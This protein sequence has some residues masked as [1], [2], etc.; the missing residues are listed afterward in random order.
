MSW[1]CRR[2]GTPFAILQCQKKA[3]EYKPNIIFL[4]ETRL[5]K[6]KGEAILQRCGFWNSWEYL[7]EGFS[8]GLLLG[9][10][11]D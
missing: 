5:A 7:K 8:G 4:M 6:D 10:L 11:Q 9:W 2:L 1:N 3:Q